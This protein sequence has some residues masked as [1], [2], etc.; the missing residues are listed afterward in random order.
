MNKNVLFFAGFFCCLS[1]SSC[2]SKQAVVSKYY[3]IEIPVSTVPAVPDSAQLIPIRCEIARVEMSPLYDRSQIINRS[4]SHEVTFYRYH[5]WAVR[6]SLAIGA[7]IE[8]YMQ[9][10]KLFESVSARYSKV[11]PD[12]L[13]NTQIHRLEVLEE[14]GRLT[15]HLELEFRI[16]DHKD[17][18][19]LLRHRAD[20]KEVL[21]Q[22]DLNLFSRTVSEILL[23]E[24][25]KFNKQIRE[26]REILEKAS[27]HES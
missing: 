18:R 11:I 13:F 8:N 19:V 7:F 6:P 15:A 27:K 22:K 20:R 17:D 16:L 23:T 21:E 24:L 3:T 12:Y 14:R 5:Q 9:D 1:L 25:N 10:S 26:Q 4:D 2:I